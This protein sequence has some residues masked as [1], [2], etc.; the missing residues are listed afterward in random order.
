M[1]RHCCTNQQTT[2]KESRISRKEK[3]LALKINFK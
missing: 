2:T 3:K 1:L